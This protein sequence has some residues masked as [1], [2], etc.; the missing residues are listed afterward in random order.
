MCIRASRVSARQ[1]TFELLRV[2]LFGKSSKTTWRSGVGNSGGKLAA[3]SSQF[4]NCRRE[5][6]HYHRSE[7][8]MKEVD[9][10]RCNFDPFT[11]SRESFPPATNR[12]EVSISLPAIFPLFLQ[13]S[14]TFFSFNFPLFVS[15]PRQNASLR[16][17]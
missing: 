2:E 16:E 7:S 14:M 17:G 15:V 6:L 10:L 11:I 13:A 5:K 12:A 8:M 1:M 3:R 4:V 9:G